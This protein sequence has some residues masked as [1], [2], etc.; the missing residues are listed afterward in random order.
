MP[1][2]DP[3]RC[4]KPADSLISKKKQIPILPWGWKGVRTHSYLLQGHIHVVWD[5]LE[6]GYLEKMEN[7]ADQRDTF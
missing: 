3:L 7:P 2:D 5:E 6:V 1:K 4:V